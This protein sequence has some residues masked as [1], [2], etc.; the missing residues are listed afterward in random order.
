[1]ARHFPSTFNT[2]WGRSAKQNPG[3]LICA[4]TLNRALKVKDHDHRPSALVNLEGAGINGVSGTAH[5]LVWVPLR[6]GPL[7]I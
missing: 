1:L 7:V 4:I 3:T 6:I 5:R 2:Y